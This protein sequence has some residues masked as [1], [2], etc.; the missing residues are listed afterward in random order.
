[1]CN[2]DQWRECTLIMSTPSGFC[3][4][5]GIWVWYKCTWQLLHKPRRICS[6]QRLFCGNSIIKLGWMGEHDREVLSIS[7]VVEVRVIRDESQDHSTK[8]VQVW[9]HLQSVSDFVEVHVTFACFYFWWQC[10]FVGSK[11]MWGK[12]VLG[13]QSILWS[14]HG[15][16]HEPPSKYLGTLSFDPRSLKVMPGH[17]S[18]ELRKTKHSKAFR[19]FSTTSK[20][21]FEMAKMAMRRERQLDGACNLP[22]LLVAM[23]QVLLV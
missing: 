8:L 7:W 15:P 17:A 5:I 22:K 4:S 10:K 18:L 19:Q 9:S 13:S 2:G 11:I 3:Q 1:M 14:C 6:S 21:K 23:P 12:K 16:W 20:V